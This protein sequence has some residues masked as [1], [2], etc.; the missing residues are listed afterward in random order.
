M[1]R[2]VPI[3]KIDNARSMNDLFASNKVV[4][5][6]GVPAPFTGTCTN[7]HYPGYKV[8]VDEFKKQGVHDIICYTVSD[9]YSHHAWSKA[10]NKGDDEES[11]PTQIAFLA[12]PDAS[13]AI[14]YG[15]DGES[16]NVAD[17]YA[18]FSLGRLNSIRFSMLVVDGKVK[19]FHVVDD[20]KKDAE[21]LL[22]DV[23]QYNS[24][25]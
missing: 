11:N 16:R 1:I 24:E 9:P 6:F 14:K 18:S 23:K 8:L 20:A 2:K 22:E 25:K 13:W 19:T 3:K 17:K 15:V 12:D 4:V 21:K 5:M 10:L 7:E